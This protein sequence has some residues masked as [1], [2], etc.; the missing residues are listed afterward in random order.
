MLFKLFSTFFYLGA[1]TFG[2]G[3]A[4]MALLEHQLV[5]KHRWLSSEELLEITAIA[6][7]TP[8]TIA[9]NAATFV[10]RRV[11]G[12]PGAIVSS[13]AIVLPPLLIVGTLASYLPQFFGQEWLHNAFMGMRYAVAALIA[14]A[15]V[16]MLMKGV[17]SK[18]GRALFLLALAILIFTPIHPL[19][20]I[21][22]GG[23]TGIALHALGIIG[24]KAE[25]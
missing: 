22:L 25:A 1:I 9:I 23:S 14:H 16:S 8:G 11:A 6:Q 3:Y 10:G 7:I 12:I 21:V 19:L 17:T 4:M 20:M 24:N 2:G 13:I 5:E 15:A 18:L